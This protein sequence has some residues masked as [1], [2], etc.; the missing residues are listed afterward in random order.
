[1]SEKHLCPI[2]GKTE[3]EER[4]SYDICRKC[5]WEDDWYQEENPDFGCGA[6]E[7]SMNEYKAKYESGWRPEWLIELNKEEGYEPEEN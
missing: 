5:G 7:Y 4:D 1:M 6:N 2:C 3:F